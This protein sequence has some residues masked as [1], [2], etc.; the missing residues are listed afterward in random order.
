MDK[1][2][3]DIEKIISDNYL[4]GDISSLSDFMQGYK[5]GASF[6]SNRLYAAFNLYQIRQQVSSNFYANGISSAQLRRINELVDYASDYWE[7]LPH[8][9]QDTRTYYDYYRMG[10]V[11]AVLRIMDIL[12]ID[13]K[14]VKK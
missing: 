6:V 11:N 4:T 8:N 12:G 10:F 7:M 13:E 9:V 3:K 14:R 2:I 5:I 1:L